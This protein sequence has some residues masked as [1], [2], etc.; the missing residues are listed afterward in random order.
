MLLT[1]P[2]HGL[3][4]CFTRTQASGLVGGKTAELT[5]VFVCGY[6][7][8]LSHNWQINSKLKGYIYEVV[9]VNKIEMCM[10]MGVWGVFEGCV[11][12]VRGV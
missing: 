11:Y 5:V 6:C 7:I 2:S 10:C 8:G 4:N 3:K 12:C 1:Q 9:A